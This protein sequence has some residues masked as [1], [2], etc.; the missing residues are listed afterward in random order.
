MIDDQD[1]TDENG[2]RSPSSDDTPDPMVAVKISQAA[3]PPGVALIGI[4]RRSTAA[5]MAADAVPGDEL[6]DLGPAGLMLTQVYERRRHA[7]G[8]G[9]IRVGVARGATWI[10][11]FLPGRPVEPPP[12]SP[13]A[14]AARN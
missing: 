4:C 9:L 10:A 13:G 1:F 7:L 8:A 11:W 14:T 12:G 5:R 2:D 3:D 6:S